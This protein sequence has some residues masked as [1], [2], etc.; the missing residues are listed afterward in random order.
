MW[1]EPWVFFLG[2][3]V[4]GSG[5]EAYL[6]GSKEGATEEPEAALKRSFSLQFRVS[7][8]RR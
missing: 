5:L 8:L 6:R 7:G 4:W 1:D 3:K 2:Q